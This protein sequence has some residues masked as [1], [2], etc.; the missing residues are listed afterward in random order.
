MIREAEALLVR[1]SELGAI[2]RYQLEAAVQSAHV[3]DAERERELAA[4]LE[5]YDAL[6]RDYG[7]AGGGDQ[8]RARGCRGAG[9]QAGLRRCRIERRMRG[10]RSINR[11]GQRAQNCWRGQ[12]PARMH[13][14]RMMWRLDWSGILRFGIFWKRARGRG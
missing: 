14:M 8:S 10:W 7:L 11:I 13:G 5:I 4:V 6:F 12:V 1:A 2:G 3:R 9:A